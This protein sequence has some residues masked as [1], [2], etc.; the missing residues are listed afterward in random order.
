MQPAQLPI[1]LLHIPKRPH[2]IPH[3]PQLPAAQHADHGLAVLARR[4]HHRHA[5]PAP[6][7]AEQPRRD[8][9]PL[10]ELHLDD[11]ADKV[12][13][14]KGRRLDAHGGVDARWGEVGGGGEVEGLQAIGVDDGGE[15]G[16]AVFG[17]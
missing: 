17:G 16:G 10:V 7:H 4:R 2:A 6:P 1:R 11:G 3:H 12:G 13:E 15:G 5:R 8:G 14:E 9:P